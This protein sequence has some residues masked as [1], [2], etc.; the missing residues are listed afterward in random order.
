MRLAEILATHV[1]QTLEDLD[2]QSA[3]VAVIDHGTPER[4]VNQVRNAVANQV[5]DLLG[6]DAKMVNA[7]SM[8]RREGAEYDFND[9][10]LENLGKLYGWQG[11]DLVVAMFF[12]LPGR[13]AGPK[14]DVAKICSRLLQQ[15]EF[16]LIQQTKL[17]GKHPLLIEILSDRL[18][19]ALKNI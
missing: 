16:R 7:C 11:S 4:R 18:N 1:R 13:H 12:L 2:L 14:G 19:E 8:E 15:P 5:C 17:M 6:V 9:P 3:R 10:L